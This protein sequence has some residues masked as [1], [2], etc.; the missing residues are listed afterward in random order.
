MSLSNEIRQVARR[1]MRSPMFTL[2][3]LLTIAIGVGANSAV[4]SVVN[5]VLLKPLPYPEAGA[6]AA[7][8]QS[9]AKLKMDQVPLAPSQYLSFRDANRT[10][11]QFGVWTGGSV[12]ITGSSAPEQL[13]CLFMTEGTLNALGVQPALGR[14]FTPADDSAG[15]PQTVILSHGYWQRKFG[16]NPAAVGSSLTVD[17][18]ISAVIGV[19]PQGFRFLDESPDIL[20]P[21][22]FDRAKQTLGNYSY[23]GVARLK[24]GVTLAQANADVERMIPAVNRQFPAAS[25]FSARMFDELD[26]HAAVRPLKDQVVGELGKVLWVLMGSIGVVL[27]IACANV[28]NLLL[29]RAEGRRQELAT[30]M[31]LGA[32]SGQI[33][34]S[35]LIESVLVGVAGGLLG[36]GLAYA[37]LRLLRAIA[38][39]YLPRLD[40][41]AID[42]QVV[43]FTLII[44]LV[45]GLLFGML[46][47]FKYASGNVQS[48]LRSGGR[49]SSAGRERHRARNSLVV[50]QTALALVLVISA[51][52][53]IRT[54]QALRHVNPGF[55]N[56]GQIQTFRLEIPSGQVK[57]AGRVL[58]MQQEIRR[59]IEAV[60]GV[61]S[62]AY[63]NSVPTD[64]NDSTD[65]L[66]D[67]DRAY[68]EGQLPAVRR[69]KF[70]APGFFQGMGI[71]LIAGRDLTWTDI[72]QRR[73]VVI[74]SENL[75]R[76]F[77]RNPANAVGKRVRENPKDAW[78]EVVGV[79]SDVRYDGPDQK[80]PTLV[81]WP[82]AMN[83]FWSQAEYIQ[84]T[85]VFVVRSDRAGSESLIA[86][87]RQAVWSVVPDVPVVKT[88][89]MEQVFRGSMA[90]SSFTLVMLAIAGGMALLLGIVGIYGVISYSVSQRT[91]ELGIRIA[92]GAGNA[93]LQGM[94]VWQGVRLAAIGA[95]LGVAIALGVT[96][97]MRSL[98]FE[99]N[100]VDPLTFAGA[101]AGMLLAA[102]L[103]SYVP[104][105]AAST[106]SPVE[107]L[108]GE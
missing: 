70:I 14:W 4:F 6:L 26:L 91:R 35:L 94:V 30:R 97:V 11:A 64:G 93:G 60:P 53:M 32:G 98:L 86:Q 78:R 76:E 28:A 15:A 46:P 95:G 13:R 40:S 8:G 100:P 99:T 16:S 10:F 69:F 73:D 80:A 102:A 42:Q 51:G 21:F 84:R 38:P 74:V 7:I 20:L 2:V 18:K 58:R 92:L 57:E 83:Q 49:S 67:G 55:S 81:Y 89:T 34:S 48:M 106:T 77:W 17:G 9:S 54:F 62:V 43:W 63:A 85:S 12:A 36:L 31:A 50:L 66:Y 45:A 19:M 41:I 90:R 59:R 65:L 103:A 101:A 29:V 61:A 3:T 52:L 107:A 56:P 79:V 68:T 33:A 23:P 75:A 87:L 71:P 39:S 22:R 104:A 72:E 5:G 96:R 1:L 24:S 105:R 47:V 88:Q 108:R 44:S 82:V 37:A 27:L 25:G